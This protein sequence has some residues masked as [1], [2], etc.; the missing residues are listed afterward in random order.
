[1]T[2]L[3]GIDFGNVFNASG[4]R[5]FGGEGYWFHRIWR[6]F[7][8]D[9][10]GSTLVTKTTTLMPRMG[11]M[12]VDGKG[13]PLTMLPDCIVVKPAAGVVLNAVGLSG[14]GLL[15]LTEAWLEHPPSSPTVI[16]M[17]SVAPSAPE[18]LGEMKAMV[19]LLKSFIIGR[20]ISQHDTRIAFQV[21][22]SCPNAGLDPSHL[23]GEIAAALDAVSEIDVPTM[24]KINAL[25]P[26]HAARDIASHAACDAIVVSNTIPWGQLPKYIDWKGIFGSDTSPLANYGGGGLSGKPLL[27]IVLG[28]ILAARMAGF[29]KPIIGGG[30]ILSTNDADA[31]LDAG[32][33]AI[34][35]GSVSILRPWRV[36]GIIRHVNARLGTR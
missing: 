18:R 17:M 5:G 23:V 30:G 16:S 26:A 32:A 12:P 13:K 2:T 33:S 22:F 27:P 10:T 19:T 6:P 3:R 24:V 14:P 34:E 9:Y 1:M 29:D 11:N 25:V 20:A 21:N 15:A 35:L 7:G 4:A 31:M 36:R 8:L 28:W